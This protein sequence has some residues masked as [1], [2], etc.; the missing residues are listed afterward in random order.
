MIL[1]NLFYPST[2]FFFLCFQR[3]F[4]SQCFTLLSHLYPFLSLSLDSFLFSSF[5]LPLPKPLYLEHYFRSRLPLLFLVSF[6]T[7][8]TFTKQSFR[9]QHTQTHSKA[10]SLL[11]SN[12]IRTVF[13]LKVR[14]LF[15]YTSFGLLHPRK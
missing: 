7:R 9:A 1:W 6:C 13:S 2:L 4:R 15:V 5:T 8:H 12:S 3:V 14:V 10:F 11:P